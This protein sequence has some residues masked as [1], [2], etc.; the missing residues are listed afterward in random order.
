MRTIKTKVVV[1]VFATIL[2]VLSWHAIPVSAVQSSTSEGYITTS[3]VSD[4]ALVSFVEGKSQTVEMTTP[5]TRGALL[6]IAVKPEQALVAITDGANRVQVVTSGVASAQVST[7]NG[8]ITSGDYLSISPISGVAMKASSA[9]KVIGIAQADFSSDPGSGKTSVDLTDSKDQKQTV[10]VGKIA[11]KIVVE[12]WTPNGQ[13]NS[14]ILNNLRTFLGNAVGK[15]VGNAQ[16]L[17]SIGI[18]VLATLASG[19]IMYSAVSSSIRSIGR[20]PL[21]KGIIRR[22]LFV[23]LGL[24]AIVIIGAASAVYLILG[25]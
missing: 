6:G 8:A 15:P 1:V 20:N 25:G 23:M 2:S 3:E 13:P 18:I 5:A 22:S 24:S 11:V 10:Q 7:A 16:A 14:P 12:D 21:S 17:L 4:G 19:T 9:G